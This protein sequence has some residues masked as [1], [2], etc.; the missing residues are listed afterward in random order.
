MQIVSAFLENDD[1]NVIV[2]DWSGLANRSY[3]TAKGGTAAVGRGL[4]QFI[5]WLVSLGASYQR[6]HL[7]GFSL[8]GHLVGNAGRE[9]GGLVRRVTGNNHIFTPK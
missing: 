1:V 8:G 6:V 7:V 2:L 4:G 3:T 9:T 5:N